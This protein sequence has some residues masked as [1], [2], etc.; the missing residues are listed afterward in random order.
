MMFA[1]CGVNRK[2]AAA[3]RLAIKG[4]AQRLTASEGVILENLLCSL[5]LFAD[6]VL[7][8]R[9]RGEPD[10]DVRCAGGDSEWVQISIIRSRYASKKR[11]F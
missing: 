11:S 10:D 1:A 4:F 5:R 3:S 6:F 7:K 8:F 2:L 9:S